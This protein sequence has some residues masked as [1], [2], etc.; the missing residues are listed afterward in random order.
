MPF[1]GGMVVS[2][3]MLLE[4]NKFIYGATFATSGMVLL[5]SISFYLVMLISFIWY[6]FFHLVKRKKAVLIKDN[7]DLEK[8]EEYLNEQGK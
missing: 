8:K 4:A 2:E 7:L 6:V 1:P 5:R 3:G